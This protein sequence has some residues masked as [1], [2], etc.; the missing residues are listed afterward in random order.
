MATRL[1]ACPKV[2]LSAVEQPE[3]LILSLLP[4]CVLLLHVISHLTP[5]EKKNLRTVCAQFRTLLNGIVRAVHLRASEVICHPLSYL[6]ERFPATQ[7]IQAYDDGDSTFDDERFIRFLQNSPRTLA[8]VSCVDVKRCHFVS[9]RVL[10]FLR[11]SCPALKRLAPSRWVDNCVLLELPGFKVVEHLDLGDN[12][13]DVDAI[14]D[15]G[16]TWIA[17]MQALVSV[18]FQRCRRITDAVCKPLSNLRCL[19][20]INLATTQF[21][22]SGLP[23]LARLTS[24]RFLD[25]TDCKNFDRAGMKLLVHLKALSSVRLGGTNVSNID[26]QLLVELKELKLVDLGSQ[27]EVNDFGLDALA[28]C[29]RLHNLSTGNFNV[30]HA[31]PQGFR[32]LTHLQ[33][34]GMYAN[35]G[36]QH[37]FPL[38]K[39][40]SLH[41]NGIDTVT[42][43]VMGHLALQTTLRELCLNGGYH[44]SS[45]GLRS[46]APLPSLAYLK[47]SACPQVG[48][49][50]VDA[51]MAAHLQLSQVCIC[52][53]PL[54]ADG[55]KM[56]Q[57]GK[58]SVVSV[59]LSID[60]TTLASRR[61][62]I[63][64]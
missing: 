35:K 36:L 49:G 31:V 2:V 25:V 54:V 1:S 57:R 12:D 52:A 8:A 7:T 10:A 64:V 26:L 63:I 16:I 62:C 37:L 18:S 33:F 43:A 38:R 30:S 32:Y 61:D 15:M 60:G 40:S 21:S 34:G 55:V 24:L 20:C 11:Q 6:G 28:A 47:L 17:D 48:P 4:D 29:K 51:L 45:F 3:S 56:Y 39:L 19:Q 50:C 13:V 46:L 23:L 58:R 5:A 41:L 42:D 59:E 14:D 27:F 22:G 44:L 9:R 53:C